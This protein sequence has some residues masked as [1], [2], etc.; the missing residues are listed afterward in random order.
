VQLVNR[1]GEVFTG[2]SLPRL[3]RIGWKPILTF[4][5]LETTHLYL[6]S[7]GVYY[8]AV[9]EL[10]QQGINGEGNFIKA[11]MPLIGIPCGPARPPHRVPPAWFS[12]RVR[13][14][15]EAVGELQLATGFNRSSM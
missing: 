6:C 15:L 5:D 11:C 3:Q 2:V 1:S 7:E 13:A 14:A 8:Q 4:E 10:V 12:E 9:T